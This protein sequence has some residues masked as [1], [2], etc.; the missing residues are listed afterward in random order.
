[1]QVFGVF[2]VL[3]DETNLK[4][5]RGILR[6]LHDGTCKDNRLCSAA[7]SHENGVLDMHIHIRILSNKYWGG[8][9][10][11]SATLQNSPHARSP[12]ARDASV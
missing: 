1:M 5:C 12:L 8:H 2:G 6:G 11:G 10:Q 3:E 9:T 4:M 7:S